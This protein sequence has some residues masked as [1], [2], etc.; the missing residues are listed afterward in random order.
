MDF[1][2]LLDNG[3]L[4]EVFATGL[5][6]IENLGAVSRLSFYAPRRHSSGEET[7]NEIIVHIVVPNDQ[8]HRIASLLVQPV[9]PPARAMSDL[10]SLN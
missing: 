6:R 10:V 8:L 5:G 9:A 3:G 4:A 7:Y 1:V 2:P